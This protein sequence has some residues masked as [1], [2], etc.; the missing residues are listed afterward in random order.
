MQNPEIIINYVVSFYSF[1][2]IFRIVIVLGMSLLFMLV[3]YI[4]RNCITA[5]INASG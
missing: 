4:V 2:Q 1:L 3:L 5:W